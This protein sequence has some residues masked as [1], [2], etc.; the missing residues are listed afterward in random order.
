MA[1]GK[2]TVGA[3]PTGVAAA[4]LLG[5]PAFA[6][7][8]VEADKAQAGATNV[9]LTFHGEAESQSAGIV[10]ERVV[11]PQG[12]APTDVTL[13]KAPR[14]WTFTSSADGFTIA[15]PALKVGQD[16]E[17]A[18]KVTQLPT[19][20]TTLSFKTVE[21]YSD[22]KVSRWIDLPEQGQPEP[23]SPAPTIN[24]KPAAASAGITSTS[25]PGA[26]AS[27]V[28][29]AATP[30]TSAAAVPAAGTTGSGGSSVAWWI[31]LAV[32]VIA[33]A[34]GLLLWRQRSGNQAQ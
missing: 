28:T 33:G 29:S 17:F 26:A 9:T 31:A 32:A 25:A 21:T 14:G 20:A 10:S 11:L 15:G 18:V 27:P 24:L 6:H 7:V 5:A 30:A 19:D 1:L 23:E 13:V 16:A 12:I 34:G 2:R 4:A 22:G 8:E 3:L